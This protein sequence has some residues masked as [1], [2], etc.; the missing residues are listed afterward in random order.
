MYGN[1]WWNLRLRTVTEY[2][3]GPKCLTRTRLTYHPVVTTVLLN[4]IFIPVLLYRQ[5]LAATPLHDYFWLA[6]YALFLLFVYYRGFRLKLRVA[7][8]VE[9]AAHKCGLTRVTTRPQPAPAA[10]PT[11]EAAGDDA[12]VIGVETVTSVSPQVTPVSPQVTSVS[13]QPN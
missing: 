1:L 7:D 12:E 11:V 3:G 8:L 9:T 4:A 6:A 2:H 5:F 13:P 10:K